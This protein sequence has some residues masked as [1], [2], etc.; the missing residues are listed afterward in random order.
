M[1]DRLI[2]FA[3]FLLVRM[4]FTME[5]YAHV[6]VREIISLY[7]VPI[8][9]VSNKDPRYML[10]FRKSLRDAVETKLKFNIAYHPLTYG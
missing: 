9:I 7:G 8:S 5:E 6:Y 10:K 2:K 3:H 4:T 1:V